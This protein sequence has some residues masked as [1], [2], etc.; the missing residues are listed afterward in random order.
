MA[1]RLEL[2]RPMM[3]RG[4]GLDT[5][6]AR[7]QPLEECQHVTA[8]DVPADGYIT[9]RIDALDLKDR[10]RDIQTDCRDRLHGSSS[11]S[12][13]PQQLPPPWHAR[14]GWRSRPQHHKQTLQPESSLAEAIT[15][16]AKMESIY[17]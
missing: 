7:R 16:S 9:L 10:L 17:I 13:E 1:N 4:A 15:R 6:Q 2:S 14:A 8:L 5:D 11:E 12:W 3:R